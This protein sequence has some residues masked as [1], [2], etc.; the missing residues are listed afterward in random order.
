MQTGPPVTPGL[1]DSIARAT[2]VRDRDDFDRAT[3]ELVF[4][5]ARPQCVKLYRLVGDDKERRVQLSVR[6]DDLGVQQL[7]PPE[8]FEAN[9]AVSTLAHWNECVLLGDIVHYVPAEHEPANR[10]TTRL[11]TVFPIEGERGVVG[12]IEVEF[13]GRRPALRPVEAQVLRA[14]LG[15]L[16]NHLNALDYGERDTLT[17]LLNRRTFESTFAKRRNAQRHSR[18]GTSSR[19][20]L[21]V[22]D[23]DKFKVIN[24]TFGHLFG[25]EVLLLAARKMVDTFR[26]SEQI[27]RFGGEEFVVILDCPDEAGA[28]VAFERMRANLAESPFPQVGQVTV[29]IGFTAIEVTDVPASTIER[30]DAALYYAKTH[31][32]NRSLCY[33]AL[34]RDGRINAR[35]RVENGEIELF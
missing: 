14:S 1:I 31:G 16:R 11:H 23:I 7:P 20:W 12:L 32:R 13:A 28:T 34:V 2:S 10:Q 29:S 15:I 9:P 5:Y 30:A 22:A 4:D 18:R 6:V 8:N 24:D 21:A 3:A 17:G 26:T 35:Q 33:E 25:D 27:F 19:N